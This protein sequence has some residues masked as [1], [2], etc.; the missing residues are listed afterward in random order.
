MSAPGV[1]VAHPVLDRTPKSHKEA[2]SLY[3]M[4]DGTRRIGGRDEFV[5]EHQGS[6][7]FAWKETYRKTINDVIQDLERNAKAW[8]QFYAKYREGERVD[9]GPVFCQRGLLCT[10]FVANGEAYTAFHGTQHKGSFLGFGGELVTVTMA[11]GKVV[12]SNNLWHSGTIPHYL[13][14]VLKDNATLVWGR[15]KA[16]G[17]TA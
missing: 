17:S 6:I 16:T 7:G 2:V 5:G 9:V 4:K 15:A 12:E 14:D 13:R 11:D 10:S 8:L 3:S 1:Q